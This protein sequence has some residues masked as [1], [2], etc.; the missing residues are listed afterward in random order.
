MTWIEIA[1]ACCVSGL[2][3]VFAQFWRLLFSDAD[4]TRYVRRAAPVVEAAT[5]VPDP[6]ERDPEWDRVVERR[7]AEVTANVET[8]LDAR[9]QVA[10][11]RQEVAGVFVGRD[12]G[13]RRANAW[14]SIKRLETMA[15]ALREQDPTAAAFVNDQ[16]GGILRIKGVVTHEQMRE[17]SRHFVDEMKSAPPLVVLNEGVEI[18][19]VPSVPSS[20]VLHLDRPMRALTDCRYGHWDYH[21]LDG[22]GGPGRVLRVC[23]C[24]S[25]FTSWTEPI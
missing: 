20:E 7:L 1:A 21:R 5:P 13:S 12:E 14:W 24:C 3:V 19:S 6:I 17:L 18:R 11:L 9:R 15:D 22:D 25:P 4:G 10:A 23:E 16:P 2:V 8:L